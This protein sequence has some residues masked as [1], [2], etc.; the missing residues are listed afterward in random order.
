MPDQTLNDIDAA[1]RCIE[2]TVL[3]KGSSI[4]QAKLLL[5]AALAAAA[6]LTSGC[7]APRYNWYKQGA[8][9]MERTN[10]LSECQYQIKLNKTDS[11]SR[12]ELLKLCM[13][14]KGYRWRQVG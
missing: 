1:F 5:S 2:L 4:L 6:V 14:G 8:S 9:D 10:N 11:A 12:D 3:Y 7:A 13:Q